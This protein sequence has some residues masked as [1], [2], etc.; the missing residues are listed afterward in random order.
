MAHT[1]ALTV[2]GAR[3]TKRYV[4]W[5]RDEHL[6]E[7]AVL[8]LVHRHEPD[9]VP[10]P[11]YAD[12]A[13]DPPTV[14]MSLV[15]GEPLDGALGTARSLALGAAL[16]RL[17]RVPHDELAGAWPWS[18]DLG[19]ARLLTAGPR[20]DGGITAEAYDAAVSWWS[21]PDPER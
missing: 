19:F 5:G 15:P 11:L 10:Q 21:G 17:W 9:L 14:T 6:R 12:L 3:L 4:S 18:D 7:W 8:R 1:H 20:P 13:A 2:E 16:T